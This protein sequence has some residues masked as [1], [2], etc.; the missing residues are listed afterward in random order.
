MLGDLVQ[1]FFE[2]LREFWPIHICM[3]WERANIFR[4]GKYWR[5]VGPGWY[6]VIPFFWDFR[7]DS[8][9]RTT[10]VTPLQT[11]DTKEGGS[12]TFSAS[13]QVEITDLKAAMVNVEAYDSTAVEDTSSL[14]ADT[15][16]RAT[17]RQLEIENRAEL[18]RKC[19][20][21]LDAELGEYGLRV[22]TLRFNNYMRNMK[23]YRLFN[24]QVYT[25][26][27]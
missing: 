22:I 16:M 1:K 12:L 8:T 27:S 15:L 6:L 24:D 13:I 19:R 11:I 18:L 17:P 20:E 3:E 23:V 25:S 10:Y 2:F 14:L 21:R 5:T 4:F 26:M 9:V 7:S